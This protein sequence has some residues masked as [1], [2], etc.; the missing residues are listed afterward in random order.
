MT[1]RPWTSQ[2]IATLRAIY[3]ETPT[4]AV[5]EQPMALPGG[6]A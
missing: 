1:R 3:A 4:A 2:D 6:D 5:A